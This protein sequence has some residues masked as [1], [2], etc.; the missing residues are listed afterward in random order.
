M[1]NQEKNRGDIADR[2]LCY[3]K[4][5]I[6]WFLIILGLVIAGL[7]IV[8]LSTIDEINKTAEK[9]VD[10]II[11]KQEKIW[12]ARFDDLE[13]RLINKVSPSSAALYRRMEYW[14]DT[15]WGKD[16]EP[17]RDSQKV[18][19]ICDLILKTYPNDDTAFY[20]KSFSYALLDNKKE[21]LENLKIA[22][23]MNSFWKEHSKK[24]VD[25]K[26]VCDMKEFKKIVEGECEFEY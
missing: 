8:G 5:T 15:R 12:E 20:Y 3:C 22:I 6:N 2:A 14:N 1:T 23:E 24:D 7:T 10:S 9:K 17:I 19:D 4:Q 21:A 16:G 11:E 13:K 25:F 18:I 26:N